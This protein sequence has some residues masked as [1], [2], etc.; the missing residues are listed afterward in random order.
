MNDPNKRAIYGQLCHP[1]MKQDFLR[2]VRG[3]ISGGD[4]GVKGTT[5]Q[6]QRRAFW[7][8]W[9]RDVKRFC[10]CCMSCQEYFR[11]QLPRSAPLQPLA[12]GTP[13]EPLHLD[14]T[15]PYRW[16]SSSSSVNRRKGVY[17]DLL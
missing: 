15:G 2:G 11:G 10:Q 6:V 7:Y 8:G 5:I 1:P 9:R 12:A 16:C 3:G 17:L 13:F 14:L 4:L